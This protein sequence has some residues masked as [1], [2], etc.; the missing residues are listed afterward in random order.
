VVA[1][2][3]I[4]L[5]QKPAP[6]NTG[7]ELFTPPITYTADI[8]DGTNLGRADA[9]VVMEVYSDF[10][11]PICADL[12]L[13]EY[14]TLKSELVDAGIL[15]IESRDLAFVGGSSVP[16]ES[17]DLATG[18]VCAAQQNRY[19]QFHDF[20]FW[21]QGG[22]NKGDHDA[23][24]IAA[25]ANRA[26]VDMTAWNACIDAGEVQDSVLSETQTAL[27]KGINATPTIVLNG[28]TPVAGVPN[29]DSLIASIRAMA[30]A[31]SSSPVP[32]AVP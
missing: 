24:F 2:A 32:T 23:A 21:N 31:A 15:R 27:S 1:V 28:G 26:G 16:N 19:W 14:A 8:V 3:I 18:A 13:E 17:V 29:L 5:N 6:T 25:V 4:V 20:V 30:A 11:C 9:P 10:Q 12:V 22:E 7:G